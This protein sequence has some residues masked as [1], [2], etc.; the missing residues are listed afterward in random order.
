MTISIIAAVLVLALFLLA[1]GAYNK[2]IRLRNAVEEGFGQID[3]QLQ[4][5]ND[6]IP[7]LVETV[8]GYASHERQAL[9]A[10]ISARAKGMGAG[11]VGEKAAAD[12]AITGALRQLL[13][14][15]EAYPDLK[16]N[17]NFLSLQEELAGTENKI[18]FA[19]QRYN[20]Q[21]RVLNVAVETIP[22]N[23]IANLFKINRAE[24][25]EADESARTVPQVKF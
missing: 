14:I 12:N 25:F 13:A 23:L 18:G 11:T 4:R 3:V 21:V 9:E 8:K 10:V 5:R 24:Y 15:A 20:D 16:A 1:I 7:N 2:L 17:T 22:T 6:L 19:R